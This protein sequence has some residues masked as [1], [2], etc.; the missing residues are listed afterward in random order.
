[1]PHHKEKPWEAGAVE[2]VEAV[3]AASAMVEEAKARAVE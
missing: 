3:E 2:V 1:M